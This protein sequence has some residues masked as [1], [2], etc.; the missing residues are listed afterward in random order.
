MIPAEA[1]RT[2]ARTGTS[3]VLEISSE[4]SAESIL[5]AILSRPEAGLVECPVRTPMCPSARLTI[6]RDRR[7][8]LLAVAREGLA[9]LRSIGQAYRWLIENRALIGMAVPQ[10]MIDAH[11]FPRLRLLVD[12]AD[13]SAEALQPMLQSGHVTVEA[14]RRLR[15]GDR[16]GLLL[17]A[18]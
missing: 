9:E 11:R 6:D 3:E 2:S 18:A 12:Q 14:Y 17:D 7:V 4:G 16:T 8:I 5:A 15:W 1:E 10:L 13:A